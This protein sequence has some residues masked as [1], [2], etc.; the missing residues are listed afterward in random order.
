MLAYIHN[1]S[2]MPKSDPKAYR[3]VLIVDNDSSE[4]VTGQQ[5]LGSSVMAELTHGHKLYKTRAG[6]RFTAAIAL[7][8]Q[9]EQ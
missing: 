3:H 1:G 4:I 7:G 8:L 2:Q 9:L 5:G 6:V